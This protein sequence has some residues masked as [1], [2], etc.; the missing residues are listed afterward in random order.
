MGFQHSISSCVVEK[1][2]ANM[3]RIGCSTG[4]DTER[5][6]TARRKEYFRISKLYPFSDVLPPPLHPHLCRI[7]PKGFCKRLSSLLLSSSNVDKLKTTMGFQLSTAYF[8][9]F[10]FT[11]LMLLRNQNSKDESCTTSSL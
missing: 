9:A 6:I 10:I 1:R 7:S 3:S 8:Y 4:D 11:Q 2:K 5:K